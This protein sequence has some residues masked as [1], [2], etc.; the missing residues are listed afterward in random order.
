MRSGINFSLKKRNLILLLPVVLLAF[1]SF[2]QD[3]F[4]FNRFSMEN[5]LTSNY[6][7]CVSQDKKGFI[8]ISTPNGLQRFD[9]NRF[10]NPRDFLSNRRLPNVV[11]LKII[12]DNNGRFLLFL[13]NNKLAL[14]DPI[15]FEYKSINI[16]SKNEIHFNRND[17]FFKDS[18]GNIFMCV[19]DYGLLIYDQKEQIFKDQ[20]IPIK[21]PPKW[22]VNSIFEDPTKSYYWIAS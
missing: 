3:K 18:R 12:Q 1:G 14:F 16:I 11:V 5:G 7:R 15:T 19:A 17:K 6:V 20:N 2:A 22:G 13:S 10:I 9:G 8:W 21:L 4:L